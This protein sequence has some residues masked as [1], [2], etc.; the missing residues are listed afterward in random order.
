MVLQPK[1]KN[2][3]IEYWK[4]CDM[5]EFGERILEDKGLSMEMGRVM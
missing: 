2:N 3:K 1:L 4:T 5:K